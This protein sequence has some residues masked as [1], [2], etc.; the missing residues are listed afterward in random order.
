MTP[1]LSDVVP[2]ELLIICHRPLACRAIALAK[3]GHLSPVTDFLAVEAKLKCVNA[4]QAGSEK[5]FGRIVDLA[6]GICVA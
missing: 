3:A 5:T 1:G 6:C 4:A 2:K